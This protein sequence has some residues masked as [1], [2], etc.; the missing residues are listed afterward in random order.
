MQNYKNHIRY[1]APHH[2][3]FYPLALLLIVFGIRGVLKNDAQKSIW[4]AIVFL[5]ILV[6]WVAFMMRQHY[7]LL[8][9]DRIVRLELRFRFFELTGNRLESFETQLDI[10]QLAA[11]RFAPD[12]ELETLVTRAVK[13]NLSADEIKKSIKNWYP[14]NMRV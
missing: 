4:I 3:I 5:S 9:Q 2:F 7:S 11:L 8:N 14:D 12:E 13:E 10:S 6:T 1:Y